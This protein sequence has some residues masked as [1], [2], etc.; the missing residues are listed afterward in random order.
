MWLPK[1]GAPNKPGNGA[2]NKSGDGDI[3]EEYDDGEVSGEES[4]DYGEDYDDDSIEDEFEAVE[5][6]VQQVL[7]GLQRKIM[8]IMT[9]P[10]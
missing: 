6:G 7:A 4:E 8:S 2:P 5:T 1:G 9:V 10:P 3:I